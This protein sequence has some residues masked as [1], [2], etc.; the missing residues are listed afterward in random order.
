MEKITKIFEEIKNISK[1]ENI[2]NQLKQMA[3][4][5]KKE[6]E[7][8]SE[9]LDKSLEILNLIVSDFKRLCKEAQSKEV[10]IRRMLDFSNFT[11]I[12]I[13]E[14][15]NKLNNSKSQIEKLKERVNSLSQNIEENQ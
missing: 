5:L 15:I 4:N 3:D 2:N 10:F 11:Y 1:S 6:L 9:D 14:V 8:L 7:K 13:R 12:S